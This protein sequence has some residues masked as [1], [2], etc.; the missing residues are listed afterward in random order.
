MSVKD[1]FWPRICYF[2]Y[3]QEWSPTQRTYI[4]STNCCD[5]FLRQRSGLL[6]T[7][8]WSLFGGFFCVN[9]TK[10]RPRSCVPL[11]K[12]WRNILIRISMWKAVTSKLKWIFVIVIDC[13]FIIKKYL[14][15]YRFI[16]LWKSQKC[17]G[18]LLLGHPVK[19]SIL[20]HKINKK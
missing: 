9:G 11:Q 17:V 19:L 12:N 2:V 6:T 20:H 13:T 18:L 16:N 5:H 7:K 15:F 3:L 1:Y 8:I 10:Y 14:F 4:L